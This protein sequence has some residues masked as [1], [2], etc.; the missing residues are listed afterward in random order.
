MKKNEDALEEI[1]VS[2]FSF[3]N[4]GLFTTCIECERYLLQHGCEYVIEK[5]IRNYP[6]YQTTD[7]IFDYAICMEC[8][9]KMHQELSR[10]SMITVQKYFSENVDL[11][12]WR[13][14]VQEAPNVHH[15]TRTCLVKNTSAEDSTEFQ[16]YAHC[17]G[18][19]LNM[20]NPP[21]MISGEALAEIVE[22]LSKKTRDELDGFFNR[23]FAPAPG[24]LAPGPNPKLIL[25]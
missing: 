18:N 23:H 10:E 17:V 15:L 24:L 14:R 5:A 6:G 4:E 12:A 13:K 25:F 7:V 21:Y 22:V 20:Q 3:H 11:Q 1:P 16:I 9:R 2:F 8:V 19:K